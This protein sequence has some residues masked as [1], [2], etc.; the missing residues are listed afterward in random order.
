MLIWIVV[1]RAKTVQQKADLGM[2][3]EFFVWKVR[4]VLELASDLGLGPHR[5]Q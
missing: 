2:R 5:T 3:V 1:W 4:K